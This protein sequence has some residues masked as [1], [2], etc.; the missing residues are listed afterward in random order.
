LLAIWVGVLDATQAA[1]RAIRLRN[2][3]I[4]TETVGGM[5][6]PGTAGQANEA[7][8]SGLYL[9]QFTNSFQSA[10]QQELRT[11][12]V[13][14]LC[15]VP[16]DAFVARLDLAQLGQLKAMSFVH[17]IGEYRA[18]HKL[19]GALQTALRGQHAGAPLAVS[20]MISPK[21]TAAEQADARG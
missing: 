4:V 1:P 19:H 21:A 18:G 5:T 14:L 12:R 10:W 16:D 7:P 6:T 13:E 11:Q 20:I 9:I 15:Y 17:W 3:V 2:E 8:V